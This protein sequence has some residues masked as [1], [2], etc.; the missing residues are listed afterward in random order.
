MNTQF[1]AIHQYIQDNKKNITDML[2]DLVKIP[3][4][5]S[6]AK[7]GAMFGENCRS[8][9]LRVEE[10]LGDIGMDTHTHKDHAYT[11]GRTKG[12]GKTIGLFCHADVVAA[13]EEDW[14]ITKPFEPIVKDG[15]L[16][17]RGVDDNKSGLVNSI[18]AIKAM[19]HVGI[20]PKSSIIIYAGGNE[21]C[22]MSDLEIFNSEQPSPDFSFVPDNAYPVCRGE[23][24]IMRFWARFRT[25]F[26]NI[27]SIS[28]G[29][30]LNIVLGSVD[31]EMKYS[32]V[33][34]EQLKK[35]CD[36]KN[37][38]TLTSGNTITLTAKGRS[39]HAA[40]SDDSVNALYVLIQ[41]LK[42]CDALGDDIK[43]LLE[44]E[45]LVADP[46]S[47]TVGQGTE[48]P[49]FKKTTCTNGIVNT[50]NGMLNISF[51][52]RYGTEIDIDAFIEGYRQ[53][54]DGMNADIDVTERD[55]GYV[56]PKDTPIIQEMTKAWQNITGDTRESYL[57]YGGTYA[58]HLKNAVSIGTC[59]PTATPLDLPDGHGGAH[60]PAEIIEIEGLLKSIE[61]LTQMI[62]KADESLHA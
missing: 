62:L 10:L 22:G 55:D 26:K 54:L 49:E 45:K 50:P 43:I 44:A 4:V 27:I 2:S 15:F 41:A 25:P 56:I 32:D 48:D 24:G 35:Y 40:Y 20:M 31:C 23:K 11:M 30:S 18:W 37:E 1:E 51:D 29:Q 42:S 8:A 9:I 14:V 12:D 39:T 46:F 38:Y 53:L 19:Q 7:E 57:S 47:E 34:L 59:I 6:E 60:Q 16:V 13:V 33:L 58:R 17:G 61:V 28:G 52:T 3:S 21:E 36:G 5:S